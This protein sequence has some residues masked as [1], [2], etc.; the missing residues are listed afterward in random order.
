MIALYR[1]DLND[2]LLP[3]FVFRIPMQPSPSMTPA[4]YA[5]IVT[6]MSGIGETSQS[7]GVAYMGLS[8]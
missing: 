6:G 4:R 3:A 2:P 8:Y 5:S 1:V 7:V